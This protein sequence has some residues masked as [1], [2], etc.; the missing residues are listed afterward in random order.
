[1]ADTITHLLSISAVPTQYNQTRKEEYTIMKLYNKEVTAIVTALSQI[2]HGLIP[3]KDKKDEKGENNV[4]RFRKMPML[5][6]DSNGALT[7]T[8]VYT[9]SGNAM[10]GLGRRLMFH[11]TFEDVLEFDFDKILEGYNDIQKR[12]VVNLFENGGSTPKDSSAAGGVPANVYLEV[13][14]KNPFLDLFGGVYITHHFN[15]SMNVGGLVLRTKETQRFY[16]EECQMFHDD[17]KDLP[18]ITTVKVMTERYAKHRSNMDASAYPEDKTASKEDQENLKSRSIY[19]AEVLPVGT[20]FYWKSTLHNTT[21][22]GTL[23]A[24]EAFLALISRHGFIG[25]MSGK[26]YGHVS[27]QFDN[28]DT[29]KAIKAYDDYLLAHKEDIAKSVRMIADDFKYSLN[30]SKDDGKKTKKGKQNAD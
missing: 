28:L 27:I 3:P 17:A 18:S 6:K 22:E 15:S 26:G 25:G 14:A 10:R 1:M 24:F 13:L 29:D 4:L 19:G 2:S 20:S 23:L 30:T 16:V 8:D 12:Y 9:I 7:P 5:L 21:N 11:H